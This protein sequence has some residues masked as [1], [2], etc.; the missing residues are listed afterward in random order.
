MK[1]YVLQ[2]FP[3]F[4]D[5]FRGDHPFQ[6]IHVFDR[7]KIVVQVGLQIKTGFLL[8]VFL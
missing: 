6:L 8:Q 2:Q 4:R 5:R 1:V 7:A 3:L